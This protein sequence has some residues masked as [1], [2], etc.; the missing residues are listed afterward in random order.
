M[1]STGGLAGGQS[2]GTYVHEEVTMT[3]TVYLADP[4]ASVTGQDHVTELD[5]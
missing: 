4:V 2:R 1:A 5:T 3:M